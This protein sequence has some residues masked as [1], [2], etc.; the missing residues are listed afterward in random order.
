MQT[1]NEEY[2]EYFRE[3][4]EAFTPLGME[5]VLAKNPENWKEVRDLYE[6]N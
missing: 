2:S 5:E 4:K 6:R 1:N 3:L